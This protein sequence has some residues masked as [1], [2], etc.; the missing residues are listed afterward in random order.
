[1]ASPDRPEVRRGDVWVVGLDPVIGSE[2]AKTRP[3]IVM[4]RDAA[5][6]ASRTTLVVPVTDA[7]GKPTD[8][9]R[10]LLRA[11]EG[12]LAKDSI[13]LCRQIRVVDHLR[14]IKKLG[15]LPRASTAAISRG[16]IEIL[17]LEL[18]RADSG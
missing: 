8:T 12:G 10:P 18:D 13:A 15:S 16:L 9:I 5:N 2:Q 1:M 17:D 14:L 7:Q 11:G 4:Q 3:C 6:R